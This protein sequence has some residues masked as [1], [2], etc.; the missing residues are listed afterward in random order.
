MFHVPIEYGKIRQNIRIN[1]CIHL[2]AA[3][4]ESCIHRD[5]LVFISLCQ[6]RLNSSTI[7]LEIVE[8]CHDLGGLI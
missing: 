5:L 2:A 6:K 8:S 4:R 7:P 1:V 3:P